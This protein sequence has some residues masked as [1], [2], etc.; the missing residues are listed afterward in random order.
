MKYYKYNLTQLCMNIYLKDIINM[1]WN[2]TSILWRNCVLIYISRILSIRYDIL[3][4]Y[5]DWAVGEYIFQGYCW[6]A[7][8]YY[9][10]ALSQLCVNTYFKNIVDTLGYIRSILWFN[11]AWICISRKLLIRYEILHVYIDA[12]VCEYI[13]QEYCWYVMKYYKYTVTKVCV[14]IYFKNIGD[15]LRNFTSIFWTHCVWI[16]ISRILMIR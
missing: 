14:N 6:Y 8:K 9:K 11:C 12:T 7:M 3:Q 13:F 2:I 15:T 5:F 16:S 4:V 10:F 1:L